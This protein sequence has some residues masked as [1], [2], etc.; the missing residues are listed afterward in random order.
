MSD[1]SDQIAYP[2]THVWLSLLLHKILHF[3]KDQES[4]AYPSEL[5]WHGLVR[6]S[7]N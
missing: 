1:R 7:F 2:L 4:N 5:A 6:R 3:L